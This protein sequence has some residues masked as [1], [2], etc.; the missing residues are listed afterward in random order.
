[1]FTTI[2][3]QL[4]KISAFKSRMVVWPLIQQRAKPTTKEVKR[5]EILVCH[6][7]T[8][9]FEACAKPA[10]IS[11]SRENVKN[12]RQGPQILFGNSNSKK[13]LAPRAA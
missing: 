2:I 6:S 3:L 9:L 5:S 8:L 4:T 10:E 12:L 7:K 1:M 11:A 13:A